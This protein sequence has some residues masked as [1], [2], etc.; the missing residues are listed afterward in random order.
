MDTDT[1]SSEDENENDSRDT[2]SLTH[3]LTHTLEEDRATPSLA[4]AGVEENVNSRFI[5]Y[6]IATPWEDLIAS[7]ERGAL[8][9]HL[10]TH[11]LM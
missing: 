7:I 10:L 1:H 11:S 6:S 2:P 3:S 8:L 4:V 5:D 9:T